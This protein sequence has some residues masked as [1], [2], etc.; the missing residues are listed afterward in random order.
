MPPNKFFL[1]F[2]PAWVWISC[3][4]QAR[5]QSEILTFPVLR[6]YKTATELG[7]CEQDTAGLALS[8][9]LLM[10]DEFQTN[11]MHK[12]LSSSHVIFMFLPDSDPPVA[13]QCAWNK[14]Q[15][16]AMLYEVLLTA[17]SKA[18]LILDHPCQPH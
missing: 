2:E 11:E 6:I 7:L 5:I 13:L 18:Q 9:P 15:T 14:I 1:L 8:C 17:H 10:E 16:A 3:H 12:E 4:L